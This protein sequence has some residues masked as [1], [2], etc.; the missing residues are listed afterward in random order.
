VAFVSAEGAKLSECRQW[1]SVPVDQKGELGVLCPPAI[2]LACN[3]LRI[4]QFSG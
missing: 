3:V 2:D 4:R 1:V